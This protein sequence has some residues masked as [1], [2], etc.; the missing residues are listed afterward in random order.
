M[1]AG[2]SA[3][4]FDLDGT[5]VD[6]APD[7]AHA[8]NTAL[9]DAGLCTFDE[10]TVRGWIGDGPDA[11]IHRALVAQGQPQAPLKLYARLRAAFDIATLAAPLDHGAV[12]DGIEAVLAQ[13]SRAMPL[14]V[15]TNKPTALAR[16]VLAAARLSPY[17]SEVHGADAPQQRKPSPVLLHAAARR[18]GLRPQQLLMVGDG[19]ADMRA[20]CAAGCPAALVGWGYGHADVDDD[21]RPWRVRTPLQLLGGLLPRGTAGA[22]KAH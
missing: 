19:P 14:V 12:Y 18:L 22:A 1:N 9:R 4:A 7:V 6:S 8:V 5:L 10:P 13:L 16:A 15:V 20:A 3:I 17:L 11:L 2:I 21:P